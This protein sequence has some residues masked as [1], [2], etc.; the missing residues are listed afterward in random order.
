MLCSILIHANTPHPL[1][2]LFFFF[3]FAFLHSLTFT[4]STWH[5]LFCMC[6]LAS[7][8][9][10]TVYVGVP[11]RAPGGWSIPP[12]I[13]SAFWTLNFH[14]HVCVQEYREEWS[15]D[16]SYGQHW[17]E[18]APSSPRKDSVLQRDKKSEAWSA[19][20][21]RNQQDQ[22]CCILE[23][24]QGAVPK[25]HWWHRCSDS[26]W[27]GIIYIYVLYIC[28]VDRPTCTCMCI[29]AKYF[30]LFGMQQNHCIQPTGDTT[31]TA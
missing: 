26:L 10:C 20:S 3:F 9:A 2:L 1:H 29:L 12:R 16:F 11:E 27:R 8:Y 15:H 30:C 19:S 22:P 28:L 14:V 13:G 4:Y 25:R 18:E 31:G 23:S 24:P 21:K 17:R 5:S 6:T 7:S